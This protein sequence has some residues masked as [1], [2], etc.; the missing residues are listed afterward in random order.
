MKAQ[1]EKGKKKGQE[2]DN[3]KEKARKIWRENN[4]HA[5]RYTY[6]RARTHTHAHVHI[7]YIYIMYYLHVTNFTS[8]NLPTPISTFSDVFRRLLKNKL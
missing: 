7:S 6:A 8:F 2:E 5:C 1:E 3:A 4:T